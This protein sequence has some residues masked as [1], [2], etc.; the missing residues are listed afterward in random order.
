MLEENIPVMEPSRNQD[1]VVQPD[2]PSLSTY[3]HTYIHIHMYII[4]NMQYTR[5]EYCVTL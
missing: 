2:G 5:I 3:I 1:G 4:Y